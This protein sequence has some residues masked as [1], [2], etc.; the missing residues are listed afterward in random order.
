MEENKL[1]NTIENITLLSSV[2]ENLNSHNDTLNN[3]PY[4]FYLQTLI[5]V[6]CML[7]FLSNISVVILLAAAKRLHKKHN[8][9]LGSL[10]AADAIHSVYIWWVNEFNVYVNRNMFNVWIIRVGYSS[11]LTSICFI[12]LIAIDRY[13]ALVGAPL[14][15]HIIVTTKRCA[16]L[17]ITV[18][19]IYIQVVITY[20]SCCGE[21]KKLPGEKTSK[22]RQLRMSTNAAKSNKMLT[23][24]II[25]TGV[26]ILT[27]VPASVGYILIHN[28][29]LFHENVLIIFGCDFLQICNSIVNPII[30][31]FRL[32]EF[33]KALQEIR[34]CI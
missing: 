17:V 29:Y 11:S 21:I 12:A 14:K 24:F 31:I 9:F 2:D 13:I 3:I 23:T 25:I 16:L 5:K 22:K 4:T 18:I 7:S 30:Y 26:L 6:L 33:R 32:D 28:C 8:I 1:K 10:A 34:K 20:L 19:I 15:Y 27:W